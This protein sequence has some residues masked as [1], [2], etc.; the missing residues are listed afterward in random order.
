MIHGIS[1]VLGVPWY[2]PW[3]FPCI[4]CSMVMTMVLGVPWYCPWYG[5]LVKYKKKGNTS[6]SIMIWHGMFFIWSHDLVLLWAK[7]FFVKGFAKTF[8]IIFIDFSGATIPPYSILWRF[9]SEFSLEIHLLVWN[10]FLRV[11]S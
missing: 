11:T 2:W 8:S 7:G 5:A 10:H 6:L 3:H 1:I 4:M 9:H